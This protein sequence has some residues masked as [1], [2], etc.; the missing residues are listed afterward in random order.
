VI[1]NNC[2]LTANGTNVLAQYKPPGAVGSAIDYRITNC[3]L[4]G[5]DAVASDFAPTNFTIVYSDLSEPWAGTGNFT[6]DPAFVDA[7]AHD[8]R[9]QTNSPCIDAGD[10]VSPFDPDGS[11]ADLGCFAFIPPPPVLENSRA[12]SGGSFEFLLSAYTNRNYIIE[13]ST[14]ATAW[15]AFA[16]IFQTNRPTLIHDAGAS[17]QP[18]RFYK[19]RLAP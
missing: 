6:G 12:L 5:G 7:A 14:N 8:F 18:T 19:A 17:N 16:T 15:T 9:L 2:T 3:V 4:W 13:F 1:L 10:P 11:P